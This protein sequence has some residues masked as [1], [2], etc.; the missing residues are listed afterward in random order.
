MV[1][2]LIE[3]ARRTTYFEARVQVRAQHR[4]GTWHLLDVHVFDARLRTKLRGAVIR[5]RDLTGEDAVPV[6]GG[7][8]LEAHADPASVSLAGALPTGVLAADARGWV[9]FAN[10]AA[11][12]AFDL[13]PAAMVGD[14]WLGRIVEEDRPAVADLARRMTSTPTPQAATFR[15][16]A[17][18]EPPRWIL[19]R[20]APLSARATG[21]V[22]AG[23]GGTTGWTALVEDVTE[24]L[25][26]ENELAHRATHDVLTGLPNRALLE[27]RLRQACGRLQRDASSVTVL[28]IDLDRFKDVNDRYGHQAG[29]RVLVEVGHRL[30]RI[31]RQID[32]VAR[33]GGDEF[34]AVCESL[35]DGEADRIVARV[36][37]TLT[38]PIPVD[39]AT[40]TLGASV[41]VVVTTD[42]GIDVAHLLA[43]AD[44][45]MYRIKGRRRR[46]MLRRR[47]ER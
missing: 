16:D 26:A 21:P 44:R 17:G 7:P 47:D 13:V 38:H 32:T 11:A 12:G 42:P 37:E 1:F 30:Q 19:A 43:L 25:R 34:V 29:D 10:A 39:G 46:R 3:R 45:A 23:A 8:T 18:E 22:V 41:G 33:L 4:D 15:V 20:F 27:D 28:F 9:T 36:A 2:D 14:G 31:V 24:R 40:T 5:V 35:P 6:T